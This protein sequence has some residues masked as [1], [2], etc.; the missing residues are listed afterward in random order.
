MNLSDYIKR[1]R[2]LANTLKN[3]LLN[4]FSEYTLR[5]IGLYFKKLIFMKKI[6]ILV[7]LTVFISLHTCKT[8]GQDIKILPNTTIIL[9]K[10]SSMKVTWVVLPIENYKAKGDVQFCFSSKPII[11][12]DSKY[13]LFPKENMIVIV[14]EG[15]NSMACLGDDIVLFANNE[16]FGFLS[17]QKSKEHTMPQA[18]IQP[19]AKLPLA[20]AKMYGG[21]NNT[22]YVVGIDSN[23]S[24]YK[25]LIFNNKKPYSYNAIFYSKENINCASG[26]GT[27]NFVGVDKTIW[28]INNNQKN[29][30][31]IHKKEK[32]NQIIYSGYG[33]FYTTDS[34]AGFIQNGYGMEFIFTNKPQIALKDNE[35]YI[36][37]G[38][39]LG[40]ISISNVNEFRMY[41]LPIKSIKLKE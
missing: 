23:S 30:Y 36:L 19:I 20:Q 8:Y 1:V 39:S 5:N 27:I 16:Y 13:V 24:L 26:D 25:A 35:L 15:F 18:Y 34:S 33:I 7:I 41:D 12:Y 32:F 40:I 6:I 22:L 11:A 28:K 17:P 31:Y 37:L 29:I 10:H 38:D 4:K 9:P 3:M 14:N 21:L 2:N